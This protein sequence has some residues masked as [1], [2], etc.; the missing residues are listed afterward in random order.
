M[1][2][3]I[4]E[5]RNDMNKDIMRRMGFGSEVADVDYGF[6]P[7]CARPVRPEDFTDDLSRREFLISGLCVSCQDETFREEN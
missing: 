5:R 4:S 6:C 7:F 1:G 2:Y 3:T